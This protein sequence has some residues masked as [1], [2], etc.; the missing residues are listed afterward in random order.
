MS[1]LGAPSASAGTSLAVAEIRGTRLNRFDIHT[2]YKF[3]MQTRVHLYFCILLR[4]SHLQRS[5]LTIF[6]IQNGG[7]YSANAVKF[8]Q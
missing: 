7:C 5:A 4:L 6:F 3:D 1:S 2:I 8:R